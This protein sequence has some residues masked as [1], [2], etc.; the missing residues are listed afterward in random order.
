[1]FFP[2]YVGLSKSVSRGKNNLLLDDLLQMIDDTM[3]INPSTDQH[4][5]EYFKPSDNEDDELLD[6]N[7]IIN[8]ND[9]M[10]PPVPEFR[11]A[12]RSSFVVFHDWTLSYRHMPKGSDLEVR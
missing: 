12:F 4:R 8:D 2:T 1:V 11:D 7:V 3:F 5:F 10:I 9:E 6:P